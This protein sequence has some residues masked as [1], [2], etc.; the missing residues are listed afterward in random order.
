VKLNGTVFVQ[1]NSGAASDTVLCIEAGTTVQGIKGSPDPATLIFLTSDDG[2]DPDIP[3]RKAKIDA[4]GTSASPIVYTSDQVAGARSKGDWAGVMFNGLSTVNRNFDIGKCF[5]NAEGLPTAFG[6]CI[7][8][9]SSGIATFNRVEYSGL[10]FTPNNELNLWTMNALG[11]RTR[12]DNIQGHVG[13]DDC[14]EW[15]GGTINHRFLVASGCGDD[16]LDMQLGYTGAVQYALQLQNGSLTDTTPSRDS[17]GIEADNSE[18]NNNALPRTNPVFCNITLVGARSQPVDNGGSDS[19]VLLRRGMAG[20]FVNMIVT[21]YQDNG[22]ELRDAATSVIAL[23]NP[24]TLNSDEPVLRLRNSI[25]FANGTF[26]GSGTEHCKNDVCRNSA[27]ADP[28]SLCENSMDPFPCCTGLD[29]G[30]CNSTCDHTSECPGTSPNGTFS[31][32]NIGGGTGSS[33][34]WYD[35]LTASEN[36]V[37]ADGTNTTDPGVTTAYPAL[38]DL[39]DGRPA[40]TLISPATCSDLNSYL[41]DAAY[42]GAFDPAASCD[43]T[44]GPCDWLS[45]PWISFAPN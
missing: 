44:N 14:I 4:Q 17:R 13:D 32:C 31:F 8:N 2:G 43:V 20:K 38:G 24:T 41:E 11:N 35:L 23:D 34:D 12:M 36:V 18:F 25:F 45:E 22:A 21:G 40:G 42:V 1:T 15:F 27:G 28:N 9:D 3:D 5:G 16:G 10:D 19:G 37:N 26:P 33:C 6:G 7:E 29:T 30:T 39:F